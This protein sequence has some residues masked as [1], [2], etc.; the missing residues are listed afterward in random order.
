M[1]QPP[2]APAHQAKFIT[3]PTAQRSRTAPPV[4]QALVLAPTVRQLANAEPAAPSSKDPTAA[5]MLT[6]KLV[7][8]ARP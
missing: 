3:V 2:A 1:A 8:A 7:S 4:K 6:A 5:S